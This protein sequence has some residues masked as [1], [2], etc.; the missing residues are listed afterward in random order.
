MIPI[1]SEHFRGRVPSSIRF[2]QIEF[3]KRTDGVRDINTAIGNVTL[4]M[5]PAMVARLRSLGAEGSPF[6]DGAVR[7]TTTVGLDETQWAFLNIIASSGLRTEGLRVLVTDGASAAMEIVLL[8]VCGPA[9]TAERP[10][11]VIDPAYTN[12]SSF[13][14]RIGRRTVSVRRSL[15]GDGHFTL[16][17]V[18]EIER[19]VLEQRPGALV[20]IPYDNPTGQYYRR[21]QLL[22]LARLAVKHN[23]W[24][25]SDEAY[26]ELGYT[27]GGCV[28]V[29]GIAESEVPGISGRRVSI[30]S[31]SKVW[32]ACGLRI[33][34]M[35][36]DNAEFHRQAVAEYT[37]NLCANAIGQWIF[38]ALASE[39]HA[40]LQQW[41]GRQR[42]YYRGL[43]EALTGELRKL[44]P[45]LI[46][47]SP[48][49]AIYSVVDVR[50][51]AAPGFDAEEFVLFCARE[52][53][54]VRN[55]RAYT[56]LTAPMSG[57]YQA[58]DRAG[59]TQLRI[60][61]VPTREELDLVPGL[62]AELFRDFESR[63]A[64]VRGTPPG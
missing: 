59:T 27:D 4:P 60:A 14:E 24:I 23:L 43:L 7:Y 58:G 38:G 56:L 10:L 16:P 34:A 22:E 25:V 63:R 40:A 1:L 47:S 21:E 13:A 42:A 6:R 5:H 15:Q 28:S 62:F 48:D 20:V 30:E 9:G 52:G 8:G 32:N 51:I 44:L 50:E 54:V 12:Y 17:P 33:G 11:L 37:A 29:W 53:K 36:T 55:G 46:V 45:G 61:Y 35:V 49:A 31:A 57:F 26:R 3:M 41:Y 39:S 19:V 64:S 2:A 18:G